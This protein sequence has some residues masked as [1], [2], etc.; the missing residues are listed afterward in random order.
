M[1][2]IEWKDG[3]VCY[4]IGMQWFLYD[5]AG[6]KSEANTLLP[7]EGHLQVSDFQLN[8]IRTGDY[9]EASELDT[10]QKYNDVAEVFGLFGFVPR[11][12]FKSLSAV[13]DLGNKIHDAFICIRQMGSYNST[14]CLATK[15]ELSS[16]KSKRKLTYSQVMSIGKLKRLMSTPKSNRVSIVNR[17]LEGQ[18]KDKINSTI[19]ERGNN[20]G[21]FKDGAEIMQE[22]KNVMRSTSNWDKLTP[23]QRE[24]LEII[25]HKIGRIL[26][27]NPSYVD[28]WHDIQGYAKLVE[29]EL[30]GEVK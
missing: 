25:Q 6:L 23:S 16:A 28:S 22:L 14:V 19:D 12:E 18:M 9:I 1:N 27:G 10:E 15:L 17:D 11:G 20:Y 3:A 21:K 7:Y 13:N 29:D 8:E 26:N 5:N 30:N 24:A 2:N 4:A